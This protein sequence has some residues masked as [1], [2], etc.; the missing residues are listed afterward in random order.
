MLG[1]VTEAR[2]QMSC[3]SCAAFAA[4]AVHETCMVKAGAKLRG[5]DLSEQWLVDCGYDGK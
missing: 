5:M 3:G 4:T 1:Y 2:N